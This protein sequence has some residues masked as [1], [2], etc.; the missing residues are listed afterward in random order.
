MIHSPVEEVILQS[1]TIDKQSKTAV[2]LQIAQQLLYAIQRGDLLTKTSLPGTRHLSKLLKINRNTAVAVYDE[3]ASQGWVE[4]IA[5]KGTF[6]SCQKR[7]GNV[8]NKEK[9]Y[10]KKTNFSLYESSNL[11]SPYEK[12][13]TVYT[14]NDGQTDIRLHNRKQY[15]QWY[16]AALQQSSFIN[17]WN[18]YVLERSSFLTLQLCNYLNIHRN[19]YIQSKNVLVTRSSEMSLYLISQLLLKP[20][21]VVL[22]GN[23]SN[24]TANMIFSQLGAKIKTVPVDENGLDITFIKENYTKNSIRL[25]Y[26]N[27]RRHYPTCC[28]L[29]NKRRKELLELANEWGFAIIEDDFDCDFQFDTLLTPPLAT[30]DKQ[31]SVIYLGKIGQVLFPAFET[32]FIVAPENLIAEAKN[33]YKMIDL[34]G[35]LIKEQILA[36]L[37]HQGEIHRQTNKKMLVYKE[38][39]NEMVAT[40]KKEF[41]NLITF[42]TPT[43][44]LALFIQFKKHISLG[45]LAKQLKIYNIALP[46]HLLYQTKSICAIRLGF[47]HLTIDEIDYT[48][49]NLKK[50]YEEILIS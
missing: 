9:Q 49:K 19:F 15:N 30:E 22:V 28:S 26:C 37:I 10:P 50:A 38:R 25:V 41:G 21:S 23:L 5:N 40:L 42:H 8:A 6:V 33:Y 46:K 35:D 36:E 32:G 13:D 45:A 18:S 12:P 31:G 43:G 47:G 29:S 34:Q 1:I 48:V 16:N 27:P 3:L 2:Y 17:K 7:K 14:F 4:I 11:I 39:R 24:F 20:K 44:G